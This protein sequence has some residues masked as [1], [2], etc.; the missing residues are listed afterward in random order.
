MDSPRDVSG[1]KTDPYTLTERD[2]K[3]FV[4]RKVKGMT[5]KETAA[6]LG[7][8]TKTV[9]ATQRKPA[10]NQLLI[11]ELHNHGMGIESVAEKLISLTSAKRSLIIGGHRREEEDSPVQLNAI[12]EIV[13]ILGATAPKEQIHRH[14]LAMVSDSDMI[15][16]IDESCEVFDIADIEETT[17]PEGQG[18]ASSPTPVASAV[19]ESTAAVSDQVDQTDELPGTDTGDSESGIG[20]IL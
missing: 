18:S 8:S 19:A 9:Q 15:S 16:R 10:Y 1:R 20:T 3:V 6:K 5:L 11:D 2:R 7:V 4:Y 12:K 13:G 14:E 17:L